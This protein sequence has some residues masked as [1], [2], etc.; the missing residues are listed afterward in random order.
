MAQK[1]ISIA[2]NIEKRLNKI[3]NQMGAGSVSV[4]FLE[5]KKYPNGTPVA[6]AMYYTNFGHDRPF[7]TPPR[8]FFS[9]MVAKEQKT[10]PKKIARLGKAT[11]Y[12]GP[13]VLGIMGEDIEGALKESMETDNVAALSETTLALREKFRSNPGDIK[14]R[15]VIEAQ[16]AVKDGTA[17]LASGTGAKPLIWTGTALDSTGYEVSK[18]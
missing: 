2:K 9:D 11:D 16:R 18:T 15:D 1:R 5:D 17:T 13:R 4:G 10:W 3:A 12:D 7:P 14:M 8:P 6:E